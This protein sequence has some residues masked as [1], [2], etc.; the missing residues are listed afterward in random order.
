[1]LSNA[2]I[3]SKFNY[4]PLKWIFCGKGLYLKTQKINLKTPK[5]IYQPNETCE[6]LLEL[7][8]TVS[9]HQRHLQKY[10]LLKLQIYVLFIY[11]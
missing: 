8:E 5:V 6:E 1:M 11:S 10:F 9:I 3:D 7:S 2:F 4:A